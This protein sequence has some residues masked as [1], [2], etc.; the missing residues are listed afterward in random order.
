MVSP[1]LIRSSMTRLAASSLVRNSLYVVPLGSLVNRKGQHSACMEIVS[2]QLW[3]RSS[4]E[5]LTTRVR[6]GL[7]GCTEAMFKLLLNDCDLLAGWKV[8]ILVIRLQL[9]YLVACF[10]ERNELDIYLQVGRQHFVLKTLSSHSLRR[11]SLS[12]L[13]CG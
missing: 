4:T 2:V 9:Y 10:V 6:T 12:D 13:S 1:R 7:M 3:E 5:R 11:S 8:P